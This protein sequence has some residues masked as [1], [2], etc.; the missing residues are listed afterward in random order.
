MSLYHGLL[1]VFDGFKPPMQVF[2]DDPSMI[3]PHYEAV[4]ARLGITILPPEGVMN[5]LGYGMMLRGD[6]DDAVEVLKLNARNYPNSS[7][8]HDSLGEAYMA[9]GQTE[10]AIE[11]YE[12]SIELDPKNANAK[13]KL[14][15]LRKSP[16]P[17]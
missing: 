10:L 15:E 17:E 8:V 6:I 13:M 16:A 3:A 1:Y 7:N 14:E 2:M 4:S 11:S 5:Q 12:R 9:H